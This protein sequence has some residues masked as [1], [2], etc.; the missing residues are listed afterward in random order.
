[1][2]SEDLFV[3][4]AEGLKNLTPECTSPWLHARFYKI[5]HLSPWDQTCRAQSLAAVERSTTPHCAALSL[6]ENLQ[7]SVK[8]VSSC[9]ALKASG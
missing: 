8:E 1:M 4:K 5:S 2:N 7:V 9:N 3:F 6:E